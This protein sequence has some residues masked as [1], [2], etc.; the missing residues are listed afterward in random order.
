MI[1]GEVRSS[2]VFYPNMIIKN[3]YDIDLC[4]EQDLGP[5]SPCLDGPEQLETAINISVYSFSNF[6]SHGE[7]L[8]KVLGLL[9]C[10]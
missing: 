8:L 10:Q 1:V 4:T 2:N 9:I 7:Q 6:I 5:R 3:N